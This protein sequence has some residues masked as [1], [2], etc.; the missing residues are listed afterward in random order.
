MDNPDIYAL[1]IWR[2]THQYI[3]DWIVINLK[4]FLILEVGPRIG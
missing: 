1:A 2:V 4:N 3:T